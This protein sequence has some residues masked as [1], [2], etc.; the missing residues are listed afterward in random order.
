M[1]ILL[2]FAFIF[3]VVGQEIDSAKTTK[4][5]VN[6][7]V[8]LLG[9][10]FTIHKPINDKYA[11]T[12]GINGGFILNYFLVETKYEPLNKGYIKLL[13]F[14]FGVTS[15]YSKHW[16]NSILL[17]LGI[18]LNLGEL[19]NYS[20][21]YGS[22]SFQTFFKISSTFSIG[23]NIDVGL[24]RNNNIFVFNLANSLITSRI[25]IGK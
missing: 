9:L 10:G 14:N 13:G 3:P 12:Y 5:Q 7:D 18:P 4:D 22:V 21:P 1:L 11:L 20:S 16:T 23:T 8:N 6:L 25:K 19:T 15:H 24:I 2:L 17:N